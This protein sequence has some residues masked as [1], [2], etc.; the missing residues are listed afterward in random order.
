MGQN[1]SSNITFSFLFNVKYR[2]SNQRAWF[3]SRSYSGCA[4]DNG[5][6]VVSDTN[7]GIGCDWDQY[8][9]KPFF[10]YSTGS[11]YQAWQTG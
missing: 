8:Y 1:H 5:W 10:I 2:A 3:V 11:G 6:M 4:S 9:N 7:N